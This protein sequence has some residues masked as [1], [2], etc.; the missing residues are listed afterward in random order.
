MPRCATWRVLWRKCH[1]FESFQRWLYRTFVEYDPSLLFSKDW[2]LETTGSIGRKTK[3]RS[4]IYGIKIQQLGYNCSSTNFLVEICIQ[5]H[6]LCRNYIRS[7]GTLPSF[8]HSS[9]E[10]W[11]QILRKVSRRPEITGRGLGSAISVGVR[12]SQNRPYHLS[13]THT[14]VQSTRVSG[15]VVEFYP[16]GFGAGS[17]PAGW[18]SGS[19]TG[20]K[21]MGFHNNVF[22]HRIF[23]IL[24][25]SFHLGQN[26]GTGNLGVGLAGLVPYSRLGSPLQGS[27][28]SLLSHNSHSS[29]IRTWTSKSSGTSGELKT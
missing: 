3:R 6:D 17:W 27:F 9:Q 13:H 16:C 15:E 22:C 29:W 21:S 12:R 2:R 11:P 26:L 4:E 5:F 10:I 18:V 25:C 19:G 7:D 8:D 28:W 24:D 23:A 1:S 14:T 20:R